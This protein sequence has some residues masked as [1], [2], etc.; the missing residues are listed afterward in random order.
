MRHYV[1]TF[2][3]AVELVPCVVQTWGEKVV[4]ME[5]RA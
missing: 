3:E 1:G 5:G 2:R 4:M